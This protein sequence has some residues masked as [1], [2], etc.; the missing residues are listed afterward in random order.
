MLV[1]SR[2]TQGQRAVK[3]EGVIVENRIHKIKELCIVRRQCNA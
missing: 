2:E 3:A 1:G